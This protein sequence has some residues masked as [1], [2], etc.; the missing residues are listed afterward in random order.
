MVAVLTGEEIAQARESLGLTQEELATVMG[1]GS[2][3]RVSELER[4]R[5]QPSPAA[6]RLLEAY[7]AGYRPDDWPS[8]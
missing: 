8:A 7:L 4:G 5:R 1:Y 3:A 6:S 2:K